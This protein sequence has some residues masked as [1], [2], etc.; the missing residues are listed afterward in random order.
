MTDKTGA[1]VKGLTKDDFEIYEDG[2]LQAPTVFS[3]IDIPIEKPFTPA[4]AS[5]PIEPDIRETRRNFDGRIYVLLLDDLHTN[6]TRTNSVRNVA[7]QFVN[8]YLGLTEFETNRILFSLLSAR[9]I[10]EV[11]IE[12]VRA[13][14]FLD[15]E[16][17]PDDSVDEDLPAALAEP[18]DSEK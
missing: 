8:R 9:L 10:Q 18:A 15:V 4:N 17:E 11:G 13:P 1:F 5:A 16:D 14:V 2:R 12:R 7:K 6:V 3:Y